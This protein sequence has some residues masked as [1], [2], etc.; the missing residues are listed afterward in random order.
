[1]EL[2]ETPTRKRLAEVAEVSTVTLSKGICG[3]PLSKL[4]LIPTDTPFLYFKDNRL[5]ERI[6]NCAASF[7]PGIKRRN[8][9]CKVALY[10]L[11]SIAGGKD[12]LF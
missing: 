9:Y 7:S 8:A 12:Q 5:L 2:Y 3:E 11:L 10:M 6:V 1:M 4:L